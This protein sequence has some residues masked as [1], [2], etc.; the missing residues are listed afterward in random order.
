M[1]KVGDIILIPFPFTDLSG[2]KVRPALILGVQEAGDDVTVCFISSVLHDKLYKFD[3]LVDPKDKDFNKTG[4]KLKSVIKVVK[5]AT[6]DKIVILGK[7][8][9]LDLKNLNKVKEILKIYFKL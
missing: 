2:N 3:V 6:L 5:I 1:H 9:I 4:L 7:M 8:G